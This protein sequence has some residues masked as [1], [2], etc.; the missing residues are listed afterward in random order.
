MKTIANVCKSYIEG[1]EGNLACLVLFY[2][3]MYNCTCTQG[4]KTQFYN[5]VLYFF[6]QI[7]LFKITSAI[8]SWLI[9]AKAKMGNMLYLVVIVLP[10]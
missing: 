1:H 8:E 3:A 7:N 5:A 10:C 9:I 6:N 4:F 2:H